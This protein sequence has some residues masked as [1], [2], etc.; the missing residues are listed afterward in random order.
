[1]SVYVNTFE[2]VY[3]NK[4]IGC[5]IVASAS[6]AM[7]FTDVKH[8]QVNKKKKIRVS[9]T[10]Q[11]LV[12]MHT[13]M[14]SHGHYVVSITGTSIVCS[15][16]CSSSH[17]S[18]HQ[19]SMSLAFVWGECTCVCHRWTTHTKF[20]IQFNSKRFIEAHTYIQQ[21]YTIWH[22]QDNYKH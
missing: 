14:T 20:K 17:Q 15:T 7:T 10:E 6:A 12:S 1:M 4:K 22:C 21:S 3:L 9:S 2:F 16:I 19:S 18:K 11:Q 5:Q 13:T 8:C